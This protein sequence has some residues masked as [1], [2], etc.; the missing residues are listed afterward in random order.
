MIIDL[1][2]P[3]WFYY[4]KEFK[5][6]LLGNLGWNTFSYISELVSIFFI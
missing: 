2:S 6:I 4:V 5:E 3:A 1:E